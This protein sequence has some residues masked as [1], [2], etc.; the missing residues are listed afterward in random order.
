M[1]L[2]S[3]K[4]AKMT[5]MMGSNPNNAR[6]RQIEPS[7]KTFIMMNYMERLLRDFETKIALTIA[8]IL[9]RECSSLL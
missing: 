9:N 4:S 2:F 5:L 1:V 3:Y 7:N 8:I 6:G